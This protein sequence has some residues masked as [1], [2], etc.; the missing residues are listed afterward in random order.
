MASLWV[1][2]PEATVAS[3]AT[4]E[5]FL[6]YCVPILCLKWQVIVRPENWRI[7][8]DP[9]IASG[10]GLSFFRNRVHDQGTGRWT[11][12]IPIGLAVGIH[13]QIAQ[14]KAR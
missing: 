12:E 7:R 13:P 4:Q 6:G 14:M 3:C 10:P 11:Q 8:H 5:E 9:A 1:S 2:A